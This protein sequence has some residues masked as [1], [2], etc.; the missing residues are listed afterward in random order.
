MCGIA[1]IV[2][3]SARVRDQ[4]IIA[5][6]EA[7]RHRGPDDSGIHIEERIA[8]GHRRLSIIDLS[9]LGHQPMTSADGRY[10]ITYNGEVYNFAELRKELDALGHR[11]RGGSDT[12]VMLAAF[13]AWGV[14]RAAA[15]F[16][17]MFAIGLWDRQTRTLH[18]IRDRIGVKPLY[19]C[20]HHGVLLFGSELKALMAH[21]AWKAE[22]DIEAAA[23]FARYSYVPAPA[24]I[25]R[26]VHKLAP[27]AILT[28]RVGE[29]PRIAPYW[30]LRDAVDSGSHH[31][32][33]DEREAAEELEGILRDSVRGRMIA[34]VP[35]GAFLSGGIDSSTV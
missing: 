5:M 29:A 31:P 24:T 14:E 6:T 32:R 23:A 26:D 33:T 30:R 4:D 17:G 2:L 35:L 34:D 21:P 9:P 15:R 13:V 20:R 18:L 12:E 11:F 25:F 27:G 8:L 19:W 7:L 3:S 1:G 10:V 28:V 22:I 16:V